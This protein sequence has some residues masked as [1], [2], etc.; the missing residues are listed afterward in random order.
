MFFAEIPAGTLRYPRVD[1]YLLF[2]RP[3]TQRHPLTILGNVEI[4]WN[5]EHGNSFF[6]LLWLLKSMF[7]RDAEPEQ[8]PS[9][10]CTATAKAGAA[11]WL[12]TC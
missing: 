5:K 7:I 12:G 6:I 8:K 9:Q 10:I 3:S 4:S 1:G 11:L 2:P